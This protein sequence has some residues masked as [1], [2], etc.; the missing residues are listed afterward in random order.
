MPSFQDELGLSATP[1]SEYDTERNA[2]LAGNFVNGWEGEMI[3]FGTNR[4]SQEEEK[5]F[6][7]GLKEAIEKGFFVSLTMFR[8]LTPPE[9]DFE[10]R[11]KAFTEDPTKCP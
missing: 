5:I 7:F 9:E 8:F 11:K 2:F 3:N 4:S 6:T 1:W 10:K